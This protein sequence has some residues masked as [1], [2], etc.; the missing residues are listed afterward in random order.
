V[1]SQL[2]MMTEIVSMFGAIIGCMNYRKEH[3]K[4]DCLQMVMCHF[5]LVII[6][7]SP[8]KRGPKQWET[9]EQIDANEYQAQK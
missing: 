8:R 6:Q 5:Q 2:P 4:M 9:V 1:S 7:R 3:I